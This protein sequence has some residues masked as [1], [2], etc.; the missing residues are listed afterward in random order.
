MTIPTGH[1]LALVTGI[2]LTASAGAGTH[3]GFDLTGAL[4]PVEE[5]LAGGPPRDGIPAIDRP[6]FE[7]A[8]AARLDDGDRVLGLRRNGVAKAYPVAIL[9]WH[10]IVNDRLGDEPVVITFCPLCG[11]G[12]AFSA[13]ALGTVHHFGVS[14]LLYN[15][16]VLL[17][18]RETGSLWSQLLGQAVTGPLR[19]TPLQM[20]PLTHTTWGHWRHDHPDSLVLSRDTGYARDYDRDPYA[21]YVD[22]AGVFFPVRHRDPRFHPKAR[23]LGLVLDGRAKAWPFSELSRARGKTIEDRLGGRRLRIRFDAGSETAVIED[24][25]GR[26]L[27]GTVLFWFAWYAFHPDTAVYRHPGPQE[28]TQ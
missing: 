23:V 10:E 16:D 19:G 26:P 11:S 1:L 17:Y 28:E 7:R 9:N 25:A 4:V 6:R 5:I 18:D 21:G 15:S 8:D 14:G 12:V 24:E 3:N 2:A 13:R 20:L 22:S 27:P